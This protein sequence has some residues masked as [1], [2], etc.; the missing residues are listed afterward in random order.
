[1][2]NFYSAS[3]L[4]AFKFYIRFVLEPLVQSYPNTAEG[5]AKNVIVRAKKTKKNMTTP[6]K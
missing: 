5:A 1:M 4:I 2:Q 6:I 3:K